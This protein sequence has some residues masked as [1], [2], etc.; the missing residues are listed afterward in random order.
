MSVSGVATSVSYVANGT[1]DHFAIP[2]Y[3]IQESDL[4][5]QSIDSNGT[6]I[7]YVLNSDY[8]ISGTADLF[9]DFNN[10][11]TLIFNTPPASGLIIL[12]QR[13]TARTQTVVLTDNGPF[14]ADTLNHIFDKL[15]L[16]TQESILGGVSNGYQGLAL[17]PPTG[18]DISYLVGDWF[19]NARPTPGGVFGWECTTAG[20]PGTWRD[21]GPIS[22]D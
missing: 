14:T 8:T 1:Q 7:N 10:G 2:F 18:T 5:V 6:V 22:V 19:K 9:G 21:F 20:A 15:T 13:V 16:I 17:G 3:F 12:I 11:A 4:H